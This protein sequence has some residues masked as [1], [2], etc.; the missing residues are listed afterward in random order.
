M[1]IVIFHTRK[2]CKF[3]DIRWPSSFQSIY[4]SKIKVTG[5][6]KKTITIP[7]RPIE[8]LHF[9][10]NFNLGQTICCK[11]VFHQKRIY[12]F[13]NV[14]WW[15]ILFDFTFSHVG[16]KS[17]LLIIFNH[18]PH[19]LLLILVFFPSPLSSAFTSFQCPAY[20]SKFRNIQNPKFIDRIC[21]PYSS[22]WVKRDTS[23]QSKTNFPIEQISQL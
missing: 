2:E 5:V 16:N 10:L 17:L 6:K 19:F 18:F 13:N 15:V 11:N 23:M 21:H 4:W 14:H 3:I 8:N 12:L 9:D 1:V 20:F 7:S 22:N